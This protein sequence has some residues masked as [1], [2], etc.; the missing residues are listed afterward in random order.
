MV[1]L[2]V[3]DK[4]LKKIGLNNR[5]FGRPEVRE[6]CHILADDEKID[7]A[8]NG[9]YDGGFALLLTTD[10]RVLL[11][12][13]K[14]LFLS[15]EDIRYGMISEVDLCTRLLDTT[16]T[17]NTIGKH[18]RF[19]S[20]NR[21]RLRDLMHHIQHR[22]ME[23]RQADDDSSWQAQP[24]LQAVPEMPSAPQKA[25]SNLASQAQTDDFASGYQALVKRHSLAHLAGHVAMSLERA[26]PIVRPLFPRPSLVN[27]FSQTNS[28][29]SLFD[30]DSLSN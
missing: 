28:N 1:E 4:Q 16:I 8:V 19:I 6:L 14:P 12:D 7:H 17:I 24:H 26:K 22:V 2:S 13:K 25:M 9:H 15:M 20:W 27:R 23:L 3:I 10:R 5:F 18:L 21:D 11:I 30:S 29:P